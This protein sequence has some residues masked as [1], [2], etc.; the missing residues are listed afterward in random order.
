[1]APRR[2]GRLRALVSW[3]GGKDSALALQ[4]ARTDPELEIV[5]LLTTFSEEFDRVSMHGVRREILEAQA[6]SLRLPLRP[7]FLPTP[8]RDAPCPMAAIPT[9]DRFTSFVSNS[10]YD[11]EMR[12]AMAGAREEGIEAIVFGDIFLA[13]LRRY[14][15]DRLARAGVVPRFPLWGSDTRDLFGEFVASGFRAITV[16]VQGESLPASWVG[17]ELD[18]AFRDELPAP[19][20]RCGEFGEYHSFVYSGPGFERPIAFERGEIVFRDPFWFLDLVTPARP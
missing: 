17:R 2:R 3:S 15:E 4:R 14:R 19:V 6:R 18:E 13:D 10:T 20:D 9:A 5:G 8:P 1:M 11:E 7:V 16:C 12:R